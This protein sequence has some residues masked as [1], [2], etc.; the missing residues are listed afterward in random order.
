METEVRIF[1]S[2]STR[3]IVGMDA[4][5]YKRGLTTPRGRD[6]CYLNRGD[7]ERSCDRENEFIGPWRKGHC[8]DEAEVQPQRSRIRFAGGAGWCGKHSSH[9]QTPPTRPPPQ[10]PLLIRPWRGLNETLCG[11]STITRK[12]FLPRTAAGVR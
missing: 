4:S 9:R 5:Q 2:S 8:G 6:H 1:W 10:G 7:S 12:A 3:A 11:L